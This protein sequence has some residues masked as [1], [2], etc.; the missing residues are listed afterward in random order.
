MSALTVTRQ[1]PRSFSPAQFDTRVQALVE[2]MEQQISEK[3]E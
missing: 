1:I 2:M 3:A